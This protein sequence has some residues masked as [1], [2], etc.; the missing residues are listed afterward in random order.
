[1]KDVRRRAFESGNNQL[2]VATLILSMFDLQI[3]ARMCLGG[4]DQCTSCPGL[5]QGL[6]FNIK[7]IGELKFKSRGTL[8]SD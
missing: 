1:M 5:V 4:Y 2:A 7:Y 6:G 3:K 8:P